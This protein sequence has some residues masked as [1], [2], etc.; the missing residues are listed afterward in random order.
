[1]R[2][3]YL[4]A[5]PGVPVLGHK[6]AS[7]HVRELARALG[8]AG[9]DVTIA[10]P[11]VREEGAPV[12]WNGA[13]VGI[14][15]VLPKQHTHA[16]TLLAA[17]EAQTVAV[18]RLARK[19]RAEAVYERFSLFSTAGVRAAEALGIP[20][21]LEVNAPLRYEAARFRVLPHGDVAEQAEQQVLARSACILAVSHPLADWVRSTG[22]STQVEVL[23]NAVDP[24]RFAP[25]KPR[26][27]GRFVAGFAGS[28]KPWHGIDV[29]LAACRIAMRVHGELHLEIVGG[30]P[31]SAA[32]T[33][34]GLPADRLVQHGVVDHA[35]AIRMIGGWQ[36]GLAPY[37]NLPGFYF[38]PLKVLEY[39]A[40]QVCPI[41]SDLGQIRSLLGDGERGLPVPPGN[42]VALAGA[43][44]EAIADPSATLRRAAAAR[45]YV[46]ETHT[47]RGNAAR[48]LDLATA[49]TERRA[50]A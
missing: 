29:M 15:P 26:P 47:W 6:G 1:M 35:Q 12:E 11:R 13:L 50:V 8:E 32:V 25:A 30:G 46:I 2:V 7:I 22:C 14:P 4:S 28:L 19:L 17:M 48:V 45:R 31:M 34:A 41:A 5:D 39:M 16:Q 21:L 24:D 40:S 49:L 23:E 10:S 38:S 33:K 3:L 9:A 42:P 27:V 36:V 20:H 44:G 43:I 37:H 18:E